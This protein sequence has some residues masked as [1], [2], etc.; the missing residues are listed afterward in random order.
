MRTF[1]VVVDWERPGG[2]PELATRLLSTVS[3]APPT[4]VTVPHLALAHDGEG[5]LAA[6]RDGRVV[7]ATGRLD[8]RAELAAELGLRP[9]ASFEDVVAALWSEGRSSPASR[10]EGDFALVL[11]SPTER[12]LELVRDAFGARPLYHRRTGS[13]ILVSSH[14]D[15]LLAQDAGGRPE[16]EAAA[17]FDHLTLGFRDDTRTFFRGVTRVAPGSTMVATALAT[18]G[19]R[20]FLPPPTFRRAPPPAELDEAFR[21]HFD[22]AVARRLVSESP[23]VV[24]LSGGLDSSAIAF[25]AARVRSSTSPPISLVSAVYPGR[26]NDESRYIDASA[27][28]LPFP[29]DRH[30]GRSVDWGAL[31]RF[32]TLAPMRPVAGLGDFESARARGARV[33]LIGVGGDGL[34]YEGAVYRDLWARRELG[35]LARLFVPATSHHRRRL[36]E[37]A[38]A[39]VPAAARQRLRALRRAPPPPTP[40]WL[41]PA[42]RPL[43]PPVEPMPSSEAFGSEAQRATWFALTR[44]ST[45]WGVEVVQRQAESQGL[46]P[47]YPFLDVGLARFVLSLPIEARLP[48]LGFK[49][50][51]RRALGLPPWIAGRPNSTTHEDGPI[52]TL[53]DELPRLRVI[54]G[55]G[56]WCSER[57]VDRGALLRALEA[58]ERDR[59]RAWRDILTLWSAACLEVWLRRLDTPEAPD[60]HPTP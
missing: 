17:V 5:H 28:V 19:E 52:R 6:S 10:L 8:N 38:P 16:V 48:T 13:R 58:C 18:L 26:L 20:H 41:G 60:N 39:L 23:I 11:W 30:D 42:L 22:R 49:T 43:W 12:R 32:D 51:S 9:E 2:Q 29:I 54:L 33:S 50:L 21:V 15:A 37:G 1:V 53:G 40:E 55:S 56:R 24:H 31:T 45:G 36:L 7:L 4:C 35:T 14:L 34:L 47:R 59:P 25:A 46:E 27:R 57:F 3:P 44:P